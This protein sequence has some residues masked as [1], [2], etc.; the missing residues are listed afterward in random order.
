M[1]EVQSRISI[2]LRCAD[3]TEALREAMAAEGIST[4]EP[5]NPWANNQIMSKSS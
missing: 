4:R 1:S 5:I 3:A 2:N